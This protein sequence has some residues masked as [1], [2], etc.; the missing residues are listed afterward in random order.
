MAPFMIYSESWNGDAAPRGLTARHAG[1]TIRVGGRL[2]K[3]LTPPSE[4]GFNSASL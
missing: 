1:S 3:Q 2:W 4:P